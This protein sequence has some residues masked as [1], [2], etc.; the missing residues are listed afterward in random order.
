MGS[1]STHPTPSTPTK[2]IIKTLS[3]E[4]GYKTCL[5][6]GKGERV[7]VAG[8]GALGRGEGLLATFVLGERRGF[9]YHFE[10]DRSD[11]I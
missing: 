4:L 8:G 2:G 9:R 11:S 6:P 5:G 10:E 7:E 1:M 3:Q